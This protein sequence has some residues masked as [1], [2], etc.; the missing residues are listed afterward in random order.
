M[1]PTTL[2]T[3]HANEVIVVE[4]ALDPQGRANVTLGLVNQDRS[5][6]FPGRTLSPDQ[7]DELAASLVL[8]AAAAR[9]S[10]GLAPAPRTEAPHEDTLMAIRAPVPLCEPHAA[11]GQ[12]INNP[13]ERMHPRP[14][15]G[16]SSRSC[17]SPITT[18]S[19]Y[20][21]SLS[22][23][24]GSPRR[25]CRPYSPTNDSIAT[26]R[27]SARA[28]SSC[29]PTLQRNDQPNLPRGCQS[30]GILADAR[31]QNSWGLRGR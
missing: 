5:D 15:S 1:T 21:R 16:E 17:R 29:R 19:R 25:S 4:V 18:R 28:S 30:Q 6:T 10:A 31:G 8:S 26:A 23:S 13:P 27:R 12:H 2:S 7:A 22:S 3:V 20:P 9:A 24:P 14:T 11:A